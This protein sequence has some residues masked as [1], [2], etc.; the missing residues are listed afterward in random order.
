MTDEERDEVLR[1]ESL[2]GAAK[3]YASLPQDEERLI[4]RWQ[5]EDFLAGMVRTEHDPQYWTPRMS[6]LQLL[7]FAL[8]DPKRLLILALLIEEDRP[9]YGQEI[10]ER[11]GVTPQTISHHLSILKNAW[12]IKERREN[13]YRYYSVDTESIQQMRETLF[14]DNHFGLPTK[15]EARSRVVEIFFKDGRLASIPAQRAKRRII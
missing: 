13:S 14:A 8:A 11:L 2:S 1:N 12:L 3:N 5:T 9:M 10:A 15:T 7:G 4:R 6:R